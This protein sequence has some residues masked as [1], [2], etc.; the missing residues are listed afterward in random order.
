MVYLL[1]MVIFHCYVS[2]PEGNLKCLSA[3]PSSAYSREKAAAI[4]IPCSSKQGTLLVPSSSM[5]KFSPSSLCSTDIVP[6]LLIQSVTDWGHTWEPW[7][8]QERFIRITWC[9]TCTTCCTTDTMGLSRHANWMRKMMIAG[10]GW[11]TNKQSQI[12]I[13]K[14]WPQPLHILQAREKRCLP[15]L[16]DH[17]RSLLQPQAVRVSRLPNISPNSSTPNWG[18]VWVKIFLMD[19]ISAFT[20]E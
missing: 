2:S 5:R 12:E 10:H 6:P 18:Q 7:T 3:W 8:E 20:V 17:L 1:K 16:W 4:P 9:S 13:L 11:S 15:M 19:S 14:C